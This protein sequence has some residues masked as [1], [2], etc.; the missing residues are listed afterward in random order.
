MKKLSLGLFVAMIMVLIG[1]SAGILIAGIPEKAAGKS[2][3]NFSSSMKKVNTTTQSRPLQQLPVIGS[4]D[5]LK[6]ILMEAQRTRSYMYGYAQN[7]AMESSMAR[8]VA[9]VAGTNSAAPESQAKSEEGYSTTNVQVNGVDEADVIKTDGKYI[10]QVNENRIIVAE[11]YPADQLKIIS[12]LRFSGERFT[13]RELYVDDQYMVAIGSSYGNFPLKEPNSKA[14]AEEYHPHFNRDSVK[15]V[16]YDIRNKANIT[17]IRELELEGNY[18]SSRKIGSSLYLAANKYVD[19]NYIIKNEEETALPAPAYRDSITANEGK[20]IDYRDIYYFPGSIESNYLMIGGIN[21]DDMSKE[22]DVSAYLGAGE[23]I[24]A[25]PENMYVAVT[26]QEVEQSA[27]DWAGK[28]PEVTRSTNIYKFNLQRGKVR[29]VSEGSVPG[30]I[31]NQFSMDEYRGYFR[32]ATTTGDIWRDDEQTSKNNLYILDE[33]LQP[34]GK[35]EGIAPGEKIYSVRFMGDRGYMVTFKTVDPLFVLDLKDPAKPQIL[36]KLKIPGYSD[37]LQPYDENHL[38]GFGKDTVESGKG[39]GNQNV[40]FYQGM[41]IAIFDVTDVNNPKEKFVEIIGDRGTESELLR[42][43]KALLFSKEKNLLAFPVTVMEKT[44]AQKNSTDITQYGQFVFQGAYIYEI[45]L[46][47]GFNLKKKITHIN[48]EE[49]LKSGSDW[50]GGR[51]NVERI[52]YI[53]DTLYTIS[54]GMIKAHDLNS[55]EEV[56][57][58]EIPGGSGEKGIH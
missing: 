18:I 35:I 41:K 26:R 44:Q 57:R 21:L 2:S 38:I 28:A 1:T 37:Y 39:P 23:S 54:K 4:Y 40:A 11:A 30:S 52:I 22:M 5:N 3:T 45:D 25:S 19:A 55:L 50:Y 32:I 14:R 24:Y 53:G 10:Y 33:K 7:E 13:P 16:I 56:G 47:Q 42:N 48:D 43:H 31:L 12:T 9:A 27:L 46:D 51:N 6:Q 49:Y 8:D 20:T 15:A 36:G 34:A 17:P 58:M 29:Y